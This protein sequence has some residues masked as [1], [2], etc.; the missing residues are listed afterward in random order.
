M[1]LVVVGMNELWEGMWPRGGMWK[2]GGYVVDG[3]V[4]GLHGRTLCTLLLFMMFVL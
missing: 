1:G 4:C 3:L 2:L